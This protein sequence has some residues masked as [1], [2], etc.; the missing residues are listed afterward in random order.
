MHALLPE[1]LQLARLPGGAVRP[2]QLR[3]EPPPCERCQHRPRGEHHPPSDRGHGAASAAT[4]RRALAGVGRLLGQHAEPRLR[5]NL[6]GAGD[7]ADPVR[8]HHRAAQRD[9]L[10]VPRRPRQVL[11][12]AV[13]SP[14]RRGAAGI[15]R[16]RHR[17]RVPPVAERPRSCSP[18]ARGRGVVLLGVGHAGLASEDRTCRAF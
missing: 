1:I 17:R 8:R 11:P 12:R 2:A 16:R 13:G 5:G 9:R 10:G 6:S 4:G 14:G 7:R 18:P 15:P 3:T